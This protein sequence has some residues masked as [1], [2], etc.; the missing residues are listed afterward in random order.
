MLVTV[1]PVLAGA[2]L[3][4]RCVCVF[5]NAGTWTDWQLCLSG[6]SSEGCFVPDDGVC[7]GEQFAGKR[8]D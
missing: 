6:G 1:F 3:R 5:F 8:N 4:Q 7:D 2:A